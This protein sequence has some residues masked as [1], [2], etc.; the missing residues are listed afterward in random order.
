[1]DFTFQNPTKIV[2]GQGRISTLGTEL[3]ARGLCRP[4][5]VAGGGSIK[6]NGVYDQVAASL[7]SADIQW[8]EAF[9]VRANP[10][11]AKAEELIAQAKA[12]GADSVVAVGGGSVIDSSKSVAAGFFLDNLW[13]AFTGQARPKKALPLFTVLTLSA[14]GSEMNGIAVL[15]N[16]ATA[17]KWSF[18]SPACF[19]TVSIIDPAAQIS[20]PWAEVVNG[21]VDA[22]SHI[23]EYYFARQTQGTTLA[24][25]DALL[26]TLLDTTDALQKDPTNYELHATRCWAAT[27][28]FNGLSSCGLGG[29]EWLAHGLEHSISALY[30][31]VA[32]GAGL[33]VVFP[34]WCDYFK[35]S[36][37][38]RFARFA[39]LFGT[40]DTAEGLRRLRARFAA[41]GAPQTL[42]DLGVKP[43]DLPALAAKT[44]EMGRLGTLKTPSAKDLEQLLRGALRVG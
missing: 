27:L 1:M 8:A 6:R 5:L 9:G 30:P 37:P 15:T 21:S 39:A 38:E 17:Q 32:H 24:L 2:F 22:M 18:F 19:P 43:A 4:L 44:M 26:K 16:E 20:L 14:T 29:G 25:N 40:N 41:W 28:A 42:E 11:L 7:K 31:Q 35:D 23:M 34:A 13:D 12:F 33:A 36:H 10:T 3:R